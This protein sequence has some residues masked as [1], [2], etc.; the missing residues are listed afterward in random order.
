MKW[1]ACAGCLILCWFGS[2]L[3]G[4][5]ESDTNLPVQLSILA[6]PF[7]WTSA[8]PCQPYGDANCDG[9]ISAIDVQ[10]L[11][12]AWGGPYNPCAD[13]TRDG[14]ISAMDVMVMINSW[15]APSPVQCI[16]NPHQY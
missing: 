9:L 14:L 8:C 12:D 2:P 4:G 16:Y 5:S 10:I 15:G 1:I 7:C 6:D 13:F 3:V 11:L